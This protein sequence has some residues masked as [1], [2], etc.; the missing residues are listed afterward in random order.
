MIPR[1]IHQSWKDENVPE[2]WLPYQK[3][4]RDKHPDYEYRFWTD[5]DNRRFVEQFYPRLLPTYDGYRHPVNRADLARCLV[6]A[7]HG[8][9]YADLDCECLRP[10]DDLLTG[11]EL[12][13]GFEPKAHV[14]KPAVAS[15]GLSRIVCNAIFA[16]IPNHPFW[17]HLLPLM[18]AARDEPNVLEATGPFVLTRAYESYPAQS[19]ITVLPSNVF[20]PVDHFLQNTSEAAS[21]DASYVVHHWAG[22]WWRSAVLNN[23]RQRI[24]AA[25]KDGATPGGR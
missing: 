1:I 3:T 6:V 4:W 20:Y 25:R 5:D 11:R 13:F 14:E 21:G 12:I 17:E 22:T 23:A 19:G 10:L 18:E 2:R 16:A 15:R 9:I 7:H 24:L 8:G